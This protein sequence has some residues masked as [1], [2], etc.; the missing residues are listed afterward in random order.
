MKYTQLAVLGVSAILGWAA[1]SHAATIVW[2]GATTIVGDSDISTTGTLLYAA[3]YYASTGV[4]LT[5]N[6]VTFTDPGSNVTWGGPTQNTGAAPL[7]LTGDYKEFLQRDSYASS[8]NSSTGTLTLNDLTPMQQ[9]MVQIWSNDSRSGALN[10]LVTF[11][12]G[13]AV[14]L[15]RNTTGTSGYG[16]WVIGTFTADATTQ[17]I[18]VSNSLNQG[19]ALN[20]LQVRTIPE[21]SATLLGGLGMLMLLRRKR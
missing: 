10:Q 8:S 18:T 20:G 17:S 12:A 2:S 9:Y 11:T 15:D 4:S 5:I 7:G 19:L 1:Q 6:G 14:S 13:N 3:R 16:Q 21:P